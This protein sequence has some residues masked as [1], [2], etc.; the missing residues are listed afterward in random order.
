MRLL[1]LVTCLLLSLNA[2]AQTDLYQKK[3]YAT[4]AGQTLPY[5]I[6]YPKNY[7]PALRDKYPMILVLHGAGER[8]NDNEKQLTHGSKLFLQD[9]IRTKF[10]AIVVFPQCP[11]DSYWT[12]FVRDRS[13]YP[14][15]VNEHYAKQPNWPLGAVM[16]LVKQ[17]RKTERI[18]KKRVYIMGLS[19]GGFG[20]MEIVSRKPKWFAAA[21]PICAGGDTTLCYRYAKR[22]PLWVFHGDADAVVPVALSRGL[23][24]KLQMLNADVQYSEYQGVNH[25]S[26]DNAFADPGLIPWMMG[27]RKK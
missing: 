7:D 2:L 17:L 25:N 1:L 27:K 13:K 10:P 4:R 11:A 6:L 24:A 3:T 23:V 14:I 18:D 9:D 8:D 26:W 5:R 19:M 21:A 12:T 20:T 22:L 15:T 16:S